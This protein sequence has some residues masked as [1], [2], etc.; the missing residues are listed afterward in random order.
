M[1]DICINDTTSV[2]Q[3]DTSEYMP[4]EGTTKY[5]SMD[6]LML[7]CVMVSSYRTR[8]PFFFFFIAKSNFDMNIEY[9]GSNI[10]HIHD[11]Q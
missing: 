1:R 8:G 3:H 10:L 2:L 5:P 4:K 9:H 11:F 6:R 7:R